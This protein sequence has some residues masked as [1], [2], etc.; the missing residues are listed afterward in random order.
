M[1]YLAHLYLSDDNDQVRLGNLM[2]DFVKGRLQGHYPP[3]I[4]RGIQQH[5]SV[6]RFAHDNI[7]F[8]TSWHRLDS[9]LRH[10]RPLL[11]D[12]YYDH[13]LARHW[14]HLH[15][16]SLHRFS[17]KVYTSLDEQMGILPEPMK[18]VAQRMIDLDWLTSYGEIETVDRV[19]ERMSKRFRR[20]VDLTPGS[21]ALRDNYNDLEQDFQRFIREAKLFIADH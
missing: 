11:V 21:Q 3:L 18:P 14:D 5:R 4:E 1:N 2:G 8:Q 17:Q 15:T 7:D 10:I 20:P 9:A 19:L 16:L 13:F 12:I 6:D